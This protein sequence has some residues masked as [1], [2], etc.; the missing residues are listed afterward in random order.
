[1]S[2]AEVIKP[3]PFCGSVNGT[4]E[5]GETYRWRRWVCNECGATGPETRCFITMACRKDG[6]AAREARALALAE[7]NTRA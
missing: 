1:M 2:E 6:P 3:C 7:W 4:D 5:Q